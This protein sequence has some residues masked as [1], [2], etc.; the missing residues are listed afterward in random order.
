MQVGAMK[1]SGFLTKLKVTVGEIDLP[2]LQI[3]IIANF[4]RWR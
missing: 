3:W 4:S 1:R 2:A